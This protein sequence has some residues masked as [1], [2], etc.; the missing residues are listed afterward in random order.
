[1]QFAA[2]VCEVSLLRAQA[3]VGRRLSHASSPPFSRYPHIELDALHWKPGWVAR[4]VGEF[5]EIVRREAMRDRWV[6]DGNYGKARDV[7]C[8]HATDVIWLNY[9][10][11]LV[12]SRWL[13]RTVRRVVT[14][15]E[16][17]SGNRET[18]GNAFLARDSLL[19]WIIRTFRWSAAVR[20]N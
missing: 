11:A 12:I 6:A 17:F 4:P 13:L 3:A 19:L 15:E 2:S 14:R 18:E 10:F 20:Y 1:M 5:R 9:S 8:P 16:L 7:L